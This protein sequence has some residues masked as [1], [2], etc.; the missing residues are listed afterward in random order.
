MPKGESGQAGTRPKDGL[1]PKV[2]VKP[3]GM[4]IEPP[5]SVQVPAVRSRRQ[6]PRPSRPTSAR[7]L[8]QV[9]WIAGDAGQG[10]IGDALPAEFGRRRE[11]ES[12]APSSLSR[13]TEGA[14]W[15]HGWLRS[16]VFE[17][18][19]VG[20]PLTRSR[21]LMSAGTP[22]SPPL[23]SRLSQRFS[24]AFACFKRQLLIDETHG[25]DGLVVPLDLG[26]AGFHHLDWGKFLLAIS[27]REL[28]SPEP[29]EFIRHRQP[30]MRGQRHRTKFRQTASAICAGE[31]Y[32][33]DDPLP[34]L[35]LGGSGRGGARAAIRWR[36]ACRCRGQ[37]CRLAGGRASL[38][39]E[40]DGKDGLAERLSIE[41]AELARR[42]LEAR[43]DDAERLRLLAAP[44]H[45]P[46]FVG[47]A[48]L[49]FGADPQCT[50]GASRKIEVA[51]N[52]GP[53]PSGSSTATYLPPA[54]GGCGRAPAR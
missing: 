44:A 29:I 6:G 54:I 18:R 49:R 39:L 53:G 48:G 12:T 28:C 40:A 47:L 25:V 34:A 38:R 35:P 16:I 32:G 8:R 24:L 30:P 13:A 31:D 50:D 27:S 43:I 46:Q 19:K 14:S 42:D 52:A 41:L 9:P 15:S 17:P 3:A 23:G 7:R 5:P 4:R 26:E 22:S 33:R 36:R 1:C 10:R 37:G 2:P 20:H 21:S 11:A 45:C 51:T